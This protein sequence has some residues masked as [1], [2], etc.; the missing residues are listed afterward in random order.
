MVRIPLKPMS[1][2]VCVCVFRLLLHPIQPL[3]LHLNLRDFADA[4]IQS[5]LQPFIHT[6]THQRRSQPRRAPASSSG[7]VRCLAQGHL[8]TQ[9]GGAWDRTSNLPVT[10]Q[11]ALPPE[12]LPPVI[13]NSTHLPLH[14]LL[15]SDAAQGR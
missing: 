12:L 3:T 10:S 4:F 14:V 11:P 6:F 9:L 5:D 13:F 15:Q 8:D 7:A 2:C 1:P